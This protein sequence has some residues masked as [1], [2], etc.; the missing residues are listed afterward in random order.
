MTKHVRIVSRFDLYTGIGWHG[1]SFIKTLASEDTI[2]LEAVLLDPEILPNALKQLKKYGVKITHA[3]DVIGK[4]DIAIYCDV[5]MQHSDPKVLRLGEINT[6]YM[7]WDSNRFPRSFI[8]LAHDCFDFVLVPDEFVKD[9]LINSGLNL[10]IIVLPPIVKKPVETKKNTTSRI[11]FGLVASYEERKN[12]ELLLKSF[13]EAFADQAD[14]RIHLSYNHQ[15]EK[16]LRRLYLQYAQPNIHI[17]SGFVQQEE[18][19]EILSSIDCLISLS[20]GEGFSIVPRE[21]MHYGR[22]VILSCAGAHR[23]IP[24]MDGLW[25]IESEIASPALYPQIDGQYHGFFKSPYQE[26]VVLIL[27]SLFAEI[28]K[29]KFYPQLVA[30]AERYSVQHLRSDY[31][32]VVNPSQVIRAVNAKILPEQT[33]QLRSEKLIA[34]YGFSQQ[35]SEQYSNKHVVLANDGGFFSVFNRYMSILVHELEDNTNSIVVPDWRI[36]AMEEFFGHTQF[37]SF[38]YGSPSDGNIYL[39]IF[40]PPKFAIPVEYYNDHFF[41]RNQATLRTDYNEVKE[42]DLTYI[43]A[44][45]LYKRNDFQAWRERYHRYFVEHIKLLPELQEKIDQ[46]IAKN[47]SGNY[48]IAAHIR[49]PSHSM[50]QMRGSSPT[51]EMFQA[52]IDKHLAIAIAEQSK[53]VKIFI[54]TDQDSV[55]SYFYATYS[56][57]LITTHATRTSS[58]HDQ[59]YQNSKETEKLQEGFQIQHIIASDK[60]KWSTKMAEEVIT[61]AWLL[62]ASDKFIHI[63]S[64]ISTAV[65]YIN[66]KV[67]MIYC[68]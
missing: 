21:Y 5:L 2:S 50:E 49:H 15:S 64:N 55:I 36:S 48:I 57:R 46:F 34:K 42:P 3:K 37:T 28:Q 52:F 68:E 22:P 23:N 12:I 66:P 13:L 39:K 35:S 33:L 27:R 31:L 45:K 65:S 9:S 53:P 67:E 59:I 58:T 8:N 7:V 62:A 40:Q 47:F 29:K 18:Y 11:T 19:E 1:W 44:Y 54:A 60:D 24:P 56:D 38:C 20:S 6:G 61:D 10:D 25:F 32:A 63:T 41:L 16:N 43:H 51:L 17:T 30:F 26:D 4:S 14:L